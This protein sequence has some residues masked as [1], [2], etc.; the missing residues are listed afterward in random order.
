MRDAT[1][2]VSYALEFYGP[3][4]L[5]GYFFLGSPVSESDCWKA[6]THLRALRDK[7]DIPFE[8]DSM[9]RE[10]LRDILFVQKGMVHP[11]ETEFETGFGWDEV[12]GTTVEV[13]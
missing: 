4:G 3:M 6:L 13:M 10:A 5:Y 9:D 2:F 11:S 7:Q 12:A 1:S 8:G